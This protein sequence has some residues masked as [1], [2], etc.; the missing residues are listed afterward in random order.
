MA[1]EQADSGDADV[2][3]VADVVDQ[4]NTLC[5]N[6]DAVM[7]A[8]QRTIRSCYIAGSARAWMKGQGGAVSDRKVTRA[9][10]AI[11]GSLRQKLLVS[12]MPSSGWSHAHDGRRH[13]AGPAG[14]CYCPSCRAE[15]SMSARVKPPTR[16]RGVARRQRHHDL[17]QA[18]APRWWQ[19]ATMMVAEWPTGPYQA[20]TF[21]GNFQD[22]R[23]SRSAS[24]IFLPV[25][26]LLGG[27]TLT[28]RVF[29]E[30]GNEISPA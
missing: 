5:C 24:R 15:S 8:R 2:R 13:I 19:Q 16:R 11:S 4:F 1:A 30:G 12:S 27:Q 9:N 6:A 23:R 18:A 28:P 14:G 21:V 10:V 25:V 17:R 26:A 7:L 3:A 20:V 29:T 22:V